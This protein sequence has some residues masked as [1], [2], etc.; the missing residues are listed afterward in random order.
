MNPEIKSTTNYKQWQDSKYQ[1]S[2]RINATSDLI[3]SIKRTNGNMFVPALVHID[4]NSVVDGHR[5]LQACKIAKTPFYY[6]EVTDSIL[7]GRDA[8]KMM[9]TT[10]RQWSM[11][12]FIHSYA[13]DNE[14]YAELRDLLEQRD[15]PVALIA[16]FTGHHSRHLKEEVELNLDMNDLH[17]KIDVFKVVCGIYNNVSTNDVHRALGKL[18]RLSEFKPERLISKLE[19]LLTSNAIGAKIQKNNFFLRELCDAY[20]FKQR[21]KEHLF[22]KLVER[23]IIKE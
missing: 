12:D 4:T 18:Y 16:S 15:I 5:R 8:I 13:T 20:D 14:E 10:S 9:N 19:I 22:H 17:K 23:S 6:I 2:K 21:N 11:M 1:P 3:Q 7:G